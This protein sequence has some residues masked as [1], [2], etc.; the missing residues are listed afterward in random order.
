[1]PRSVSADL[2]GM[3]RPLTRSLDEALNS[4]FDQERRKLEA[5]QHVRDRRYQQYTVPFFGTHEQRHEQRKEHR[6]YLLHQIHSSVE[7]KKTSAVSQRQE[8][9][10]SL[11]ADA[12]FISRTIAGTRS[13]DK[14][15][16]QFRDANKLLIESR[17]LQRKEQRLRQQRE[18]SERLRHNPVNWSKTLV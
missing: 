7:E 13:H 2:G 15:L 5:K 18:D 12:D 17:E 9:L 16:S 8:C 6:E 10:V 3:R 14:Y 4:S 1:M 11:R